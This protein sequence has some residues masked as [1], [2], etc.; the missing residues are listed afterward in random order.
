MQVLIR[1]AKLVDMKE[2]VASAK[3]SQLLHR[4]WVNAPD[5]SARFEVWLKRM[6]SGG[7]KR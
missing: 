1:Q 2:F 7:S 5:T 6:R 3:S 4:P